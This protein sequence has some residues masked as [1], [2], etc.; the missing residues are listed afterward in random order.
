[1]IWK[2]IAKRD[3]WNFLISV[4]D[5]YFQ[6][7]LTIL[8]HLTAIPNSSLMNNKRANF[9]FKMKFTQ[10]P[11]IEYLLEY[12]ICCSAKPQK[13]A[14]YFNCGTKLNSK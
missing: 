2:E 4:Y 8:Q 9:S 5:N 13:I 6:S 3:Q 12:S 11:G 1:M 10:N 14:K 7:F